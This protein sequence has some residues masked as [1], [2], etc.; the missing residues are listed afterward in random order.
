MFTISFKKMT[1]PG[2]LFFLLVLTKAA[3]A[4]EGVAVDRLSATPVVESAPPPP[5]GPYTATG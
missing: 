2:L 1:V 3:L 4:E 5:P